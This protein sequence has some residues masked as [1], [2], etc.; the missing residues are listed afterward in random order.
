MIVVADFENSEKEILIYV[1]PRFLSSISFTTAGNNV[2]SKSV[3]MLKLTTLLI[4]NIKIKLFSLTFNFKILV[5]SS[6]L[7]QMC[8][9]GDCEQPL[10]ISFQR[11]NL[12]QF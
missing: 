1:R 5:L 6:G 12:F 8:P 4:G 7:D 2:L 10:A 9:Y 3:I 11:E